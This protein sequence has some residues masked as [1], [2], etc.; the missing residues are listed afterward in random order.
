MAAANPTVN[1]GER[2]YRLST[3]LVVA[4]IAWGAISYSYA[5][6]IIGTT[7]GITSP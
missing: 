5:A 2:H 1:D 3:I 6:S 4:G 7:L